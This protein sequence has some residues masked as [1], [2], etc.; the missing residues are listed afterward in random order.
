MQSA[1][2]P[3]IESGKSWYF[4]F[5]LDKFSNFSDCPLAVSPASMIIAVVSIFLL[6][7]LTLEA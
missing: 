1:V 7:L 3:L 4:H 2:K 6:L 5:P